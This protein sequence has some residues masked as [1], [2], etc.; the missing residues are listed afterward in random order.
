TVDAGLIFERELDV[1]RGYRQTLE[2]RLN[3]AYV[4]TRDQSDFPVFDSDERAFSW[5]QLWTPHRF[6]GSDRVGDLNRLS[7]ALTTRFL[8]DDS[9]RERVSL[10]VGQAT[11]FDDRTID[12]DGDPNTLPTDVE[13]RYNALRDRSP[14][15]TRL[16]WQMTDRWSLGYELLYDEQR[17][18][19]E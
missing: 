1:G 10:G 14:V 6:S 8:T 15:V 4:P 7:Y 3:Y 19:T 11:Y 18:L 16:D 12:I 17:R 13:R 5:N 2:P 9:G